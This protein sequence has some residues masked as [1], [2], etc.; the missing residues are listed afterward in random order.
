MRDI[1]STEGSWFF[2]A[3]KGK[4]KAMRMMDGFNERIA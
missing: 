3:C 2:V 1:Y 4:P